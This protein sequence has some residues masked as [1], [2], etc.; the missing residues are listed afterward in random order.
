MSFIAT[1]LALLLEQARPLSLGNPVYVAVRAWARWV[2]ASIDTGREVHAWLAWSVAVVAPSLLVM[3]VHWLLYALGGWWAAAPWSVLVLYFTLGFRQFSHRFTAIRDALEMGDEALAREHLARWQQVEVS[4]VPQRE[5]LRHVIE[6]SV[7]AAHRHVFGV[8]LW[9]SVLAA[10][11]FGPLG[12]V[13]YRLAE[14]VSRYWKFKSDVQQVPLSPALQAAARQAWWVLDGVAA[15]CT[16]L[17]FAV[18]GS[19]EDAVDAWRQHTALRPNDNDGLVIAATAG[20]LGLRL[21]GAALRQTTEVTTP[22]G[23]AAAATAE[24]GTVAR[25]REPELGHLRSV[26][27]L[28][29][30]TVVVWMLLL[31][32]LTF[33]RLLG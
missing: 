7:L 23:S 26:V 22:R 8:L 15:R 13:L 3:A 25:G 32:L 17:A 12:A 31:A 20:A 5:V 4:E 6:V 1:L 29:W 19:F 30:R 2:R 14:F 10:F 18:V 27:G 33:A 24:A 21:G 9:F 16:A 11:G 28:V